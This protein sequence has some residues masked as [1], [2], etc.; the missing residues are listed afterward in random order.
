MAKVL[1]VYNDARFCLLPSTFTEL[2]EGLREL[3]NEVELGLIPDASS[4]REEFEQG[5]SRVCASIQ[6][7]TECGDDFFILDG[8]C[9]LHYSGV[10][11][12]APLRRFSYVTDAPWSQFEYIH[13]VPDDVTIS[14]VDRNHRAFHDRFPSGHRSVFLPHGGPLP[15]PDW[16]GERPIDVLFLGNLTAPSRME[17]FE[18]ATATLPLSWRRACLLALDLILGEGEDAFQAMLKGLAAEGL[19]IGT[20]GVRTF[21]DLLVFV[22]TF[23]ESH[24]RHRLLTSLPQVKVV[25]AGRISPSFFETPPPNVSAIGVVDETAAVALMRK[26]R[27]LLNSVTV[28][29]AG[30]HERVWYGMACG[31]AI[32][33][34]HSSFVAETLT[35]GKEVLDLEE[36]I[37]SGGANL[38]ELLAAGTG[39]L[40]AAHAARPIY[41][42]HHTWRQRAR[43]IH[44]AMRRG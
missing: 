4:G 38:A 18:S 23:A 34:D 21:I 15:D 16:R 14:Y 33:T 26:S 40:D 22:A 30:S 27:I 43:I 36:A 9:K 42:A 7:M 10:R 8:N 3:G 44:E 35:Y 12:V 41:A 1:V 19:E 13:T 28:F 32:C 5:H 25:I 37:A 20:L 29:P 6:A 39:V 24:Q 31:A 17:H 11:R 2:A